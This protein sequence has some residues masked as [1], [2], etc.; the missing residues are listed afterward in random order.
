M[1]EESRNWSMAVHGSALAGA[2]L[3]GIGSWVGPLVIWLMRRDVDPFSTEHA[4]EALNFN[5]TVVIVGVAGFLLAVLTLGLG[6]L[7]VIPLWLVLGV[8]WLIWTIQGLMAASRG[9]AYRYPAT[10]R[11]IK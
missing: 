8:L 1:S 2:F 4:R 11:L 3:A 7:I 10:L 9:E 6:L 5:I